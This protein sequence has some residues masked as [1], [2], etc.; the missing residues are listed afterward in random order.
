MN[1][2]PTPRETLIALHAARD[3]PRR[4]ACR[5]AAEVVARSARSVAAPPEPQASWSSPASWSDAA[6]IIA[7]A[8]AELEAAAALDARI[9]TALD[10]GYPP[11]LL[12]VELPPP[13]LVVRGTLPPGPAVAIVGSR[14]ADIYGR[15]T[16]RLFALYL[17]SEGVVVISG[18]AR[19]IDAAAHQGALAARGGA[20]VAV[21]GCGMGVDYPRGHARLAA[22]VAEHGAVVSEFPCGAGPRR[23]HFPER[24]RTIAALTAATLVVQATPRSGSLVTARHA[25]DLG[26]AVFAA[27]G[28]VF[29]PLSWGPHEL[30]AAGARLAAHPRDI[31]VEL[32]RGATARTAE[33]AAPAARKPPD[34][35]APLDQLPAIGVLFAAVATVPEGP[36]TP[37]AAPGDGGDGDDGDNGVDRRA[38]G[39]NG[40]GTGTSRVHNGPAAALPAAHRAVLAALRARAVRSAAQVAAAAGL[41]L[42]T[43]LATLLELEVAGRVERLPGMVYRLAAGGPAPRERGGG[44]W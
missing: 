37:L 16:A 23:W 6:Q 29:A 4:H 22:A 39:A 27:P 30:I 9:V 35:V 3:L 15:E 21:L 26:R 41:A 19:G 25:R 38:D 44:T 14:L 2:Q 32:A 40:D 7:A 1:R 17:A 33:P 28:P 18:L 42:P 13:A 8:G 36:M 24:N 34:E 31:L 43:V 11:L 10:A 20:T 12:G 5:L